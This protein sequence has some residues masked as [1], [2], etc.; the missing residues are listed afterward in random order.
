MKLD[1][2]R[3]KA[4]FKIFHKDIRTQELSYLK[5]KETCVL[6]LNKTSKEYL[7]KVKWYRLIFDICPFVDEVFVCN[8]VAFWSA[9]KDSDIDLF[10]ITK[11]SKIWTSRLFLSFALWVLRAKRNQENVAWR[12]CLS[13][14]ATKSWANKLENIQIKK[15]NDPYLAIW[16][17]TLIPILNYWYF[18]EFKWNNDWIQSYWINYTNS[19]KLKKSVSC[20]KRMFEFIFWLGLI[21]NIIKKIL[22]KRCIY[23]SKRLKNKQWTIISDNILKFHDNDIREVISYK[24]EMIK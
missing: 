9:N 4:F 20:I 1:D 22:K 14:W 7:D 17:S 23:K 18:D 13:F 5:W 2:N 6:H 24:L 10:I 3:I 19:N 16:T 12:F 11:N 8:T 21:E 15:W